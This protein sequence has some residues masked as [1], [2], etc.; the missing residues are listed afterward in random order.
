VSASF[1]F[2]AYII[3]DTKTHTI[4]LN[5]ES[6][7]I[8]RDEGKSYWTHL[9]KQ[10]NTM[11]HML[12]PPTNLTRRLDNIEGKYKNPKRGRGGRRKKKLS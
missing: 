12:L 5:F 6:D 7:R 2:N 11:L 3:S 9:T 1:Q 8:E 10:E 4:R